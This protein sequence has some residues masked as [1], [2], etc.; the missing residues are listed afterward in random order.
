MSYRWLWLFLNCFCI[1]PAYG[2]NAYVDSLLLWLETH[3]GKDTQRVITTHKL[4][5]RLSEIS[6]SR[7]WKYAKETENLASQLGFIKGECLANINYAILEAVEGNYRNSA[8]YYLKAIQY[9]TKIQFTRGLSISYNNIGENYFRL[10]EYDKATEYLEKAL[11][12]NDSIGELRG[13][14]INLEN[15]G[16]VEFAR[17]HYSPA[18]Q[19]W[20]RG[21]EWAK[22][23]KDANVTT[24][25]FVDLGKYY[26]ETGQLSQAFYHLRIADSI[27]THQGEVYYQIQAYK[28]YANAFEKNRQRDSTLSY[29]HKALRASRNLGNKNEECEVFNL[30]SKHFE[31]QQVY[32]SGMYYLRRHKELSDTLLSDKNFAHLAFIQTQY[33]T[34]LKDEENRRLKQIQLTQNK[35]ISEKNYL[36]IASAVA[37]ALALLSVFLIY[38]SFQD[39]KH[40]LELLEQKKASEYRQQLSELE[41]KS[42]RSQMNPHFIFNS[43]NS[44]RNYIIKNEP[45]IASSYLAQFATLMRRILD[46][47]QQSY[48]YIDDELELLKLYLN[49]EQ[50]RF[51]RKFH[52]EITVDEE[53]AHANYKIPSMVLQP[54]IENAIWHGLLNKEEG[55]GELRIQFS[56]SPGK[57]NEICCIITDNGIGRVES[58]ALKG[59]LKPHKSKGLEITRERLVRLSKE[60]IHEPIEFEDLYSDQGKATGTRVIV[61][62]PV[63]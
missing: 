48:V 49:L 28:G 14:A 33:E 6:A 34:Q 20:N 23:S 50:M 63:M 30:L 17:K 10:K 59:S 7:S 47:S 11:V 32:D 19:Y 55:Q 58:E 31:K 52:Y 8:D 38:L 27:S 37:L 35:E 25:L 1:L 26:T 61:H 44:I 46:A 21:F 45:Q 9:A 4:S 3:P 15:L 36:L 53:V 22:Q 54:F 2:Q 29:L 41:V 56:E 57:H 43:L 16:S 51:S 12:L 42:L 40:N 39:K 18:L 62:L 13:Q 60:S 5:Y 24:L